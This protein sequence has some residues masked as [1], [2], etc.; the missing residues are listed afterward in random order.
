MLNSALY[1]K[2]IYGYDRLLAIRAVDESNARIRREV[3]DRLAL[4]I[5]KL[6][7][8]LTKI[9]GLLLELE[10]INPYLVPL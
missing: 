1:I 3:V 6:D 5:E 7:I 10:Y 2:T 9:C 8:E 4:L